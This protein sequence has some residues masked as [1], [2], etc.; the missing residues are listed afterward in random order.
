MPLEQ[1]VKVYQFLQG[2]GE[3]LLAD[4]GDGDAFKPTCEGGHTPAWLI[5]HLG[6]VGNRILVTCGAEPSIDFDIW[7][8]RFGIGSEPAT[9]QGDGPGWNELLSVWR[10]AHADLVKTVPGVSAEKL[11]EPNPNEL[12]AHA[13]PTMH[14]LLSFVLTGHEAMHLGQL[15]T[16]RRVQ[17]RPPLF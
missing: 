16:W 7:S 9:E 4:I 2:Y 5:G 8:P 13:L 11:G 10:Q 14:D 15:S 6:F 12:M 3:G 17:G 1:E